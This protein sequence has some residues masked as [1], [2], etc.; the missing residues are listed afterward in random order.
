VAV[1]LLDKLVFEHSLKALAGRL[2]SSDSMALYKCFIII[3][4][5]IIINPYHT[6]VLLCLNL[7]VS[8]TDSLSVHAS[9]FYTWQI[10]LTL[11]RTVRSA[12]LHDE[13]HW[14]DIPQRV[15]YK[16]AVTVHRCLRNQALTTAFQCLMLP[17][18]SH[19][20]LTV[21]RVRC[22]TFG[23]RSFTSAGP[24]VWNSLLD[25]LRTSAVGPDQF[26]RTLKTHLFACC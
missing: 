23:C 22:S 1:R 15:Q 11:F 25:N 12:L 14:L 9:L 13:L 20:Q 2:L 3:I 6:V 19:H 4:I 18:A 17:V 7:C 8:V 5:I 21:P 24:T 10:L 26:R 16:L